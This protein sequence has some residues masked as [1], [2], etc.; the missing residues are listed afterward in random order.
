MIACFG[1]QTSVVPGMR[2]IIPSLA[3]VPTFEEDKLAASLLQPLGF[4][5]WGQTAFGAA[6]LKMGTYEL[7]LE[8]IQGMSVRGKYFEGGH[9]YRNQTAVVT[10]HTL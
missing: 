6:F 8:G 1:K 7:T 5:P 3:S 9:A 2:G 10:L 4:L